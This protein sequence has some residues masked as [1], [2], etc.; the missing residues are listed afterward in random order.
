MNWLD[1]MYLQDF[2]PDLPTFQLIKLPENSEHPA[3]KDKQYNTKTKQ[4][5]SLR[6]RNHD[7]FKVELNEEKFNLNDLARPRSYIYQ[8]L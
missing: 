6:K 1:V 8:S 3:K 4:A 7:T 5:F 2:Y